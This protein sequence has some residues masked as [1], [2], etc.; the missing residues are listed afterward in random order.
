MTTKVQPPQRTLVNHITGDSVSFLVI[1]PNGQ[2]QEFQAICYRDGMIDRADYKEKMN[3]R[4]F[5]LWSNVDAFGKN[6]HLKAILTADEFFQWIEHCRKANIIAKGM[7]AY[8]DAQGIH[9]LIVPRGL[10]DRHQIYAAMCC[11]RWADCAPKMVFELLENLKKED[12]PFWTAL[13]YGLQG[14]WYN[15]NHSFV[16]IASRSASMYMSDAPSQDLAHSLAAKFW[17]SLSAE[18][19]V[20]RNPNSISSICE[21]DKVAIELGGELTERFQVDRRDKQRP[22]LFIEEMKTLLTPKWKPLYDLERPTKDELA[23]LY[24]EITKN[25]KKE[26]A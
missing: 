24:K 6:D 8:T 15:Y 10:Y 21:V 25:D 4:G 2:S 5:V 23:R 11:F 16:R 12:V 22:N 7:T 26:A 3:E 13:H 17:Y 14:Y 18:E 1:Y 20:S 19:R 9:R